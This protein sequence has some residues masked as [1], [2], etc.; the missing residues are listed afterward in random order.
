MIQV[1]CIY[2]VV[3]ILNAIMNILRMKLICVIP[4][5]LLLMCVRVAINIKIVVVYYMYLITRVSMQYC[6]L[7]HKW[8][9]YFHEP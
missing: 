8:A 2:F 7:L 5:T 4:R 1:C 3:A 6:E 9:W